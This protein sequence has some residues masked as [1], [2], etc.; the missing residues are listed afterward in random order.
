[1]CSEW[2][3]HTHFLF[4]EIVFRVT[5]TGFNQANLS[6]KYFQDSKTCFPS[7]H[8]RHRSDVNYSIK[9]K[10]IEVSLIIWIEIKEE[11]HRIIM[12]EKHPLSSSNPTPLLRKGQLDQVPKTMTSQVFSNSKD[13][14]STSLGYL[15]YHLGLFFF[16]TC[17]S[18]IIS[19]FLPHMCILCVLPRFCTRCLIITVIPYLQVSL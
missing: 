14:V 10:A 9:F 11:K 3:L 8:R 16:L 19:L 1:M 2:F 6:K 15:L 12:I 17:K 7:F 5:V 18:L 13:R 4:V